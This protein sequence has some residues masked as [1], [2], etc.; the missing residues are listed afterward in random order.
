[1]NFEQPRPSVESS[2]ERENRIQ[3]ELVERFYGFPPQ[4]KQLGDWISKNAARFRELIQMKPKLLAGYE[5]D[6]EASLRALE[7]ELYHDQRHGK[8]KAGYF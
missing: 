2:L 7:E 4:N 6:R 1:M 5:I 8:E 3:L